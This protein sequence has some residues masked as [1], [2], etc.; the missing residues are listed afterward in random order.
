MKTRDF[1]GAAADCRAS[2]RVDAT[3][4]RAHERLGA[5]FEV[6]PPL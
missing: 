1:A 5:I 3:F 6:S 4:V 2:L